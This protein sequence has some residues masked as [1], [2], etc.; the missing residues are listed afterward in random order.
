MKNIH[1]TYAKIKNTINSASENRMMGESYND[2]TK[3]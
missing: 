3:I 1:F 2:E